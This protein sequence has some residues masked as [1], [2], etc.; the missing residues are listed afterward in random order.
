MSKADTELLKVDRDTIE[1][2]NLIERRRE[3]YRLHQL[4]VSLR[5]IAEQLGVA[6]ATVQRDIRWVETQGA[7]VLAGKAAELFS[8]VWARYGVLYKEAID[9]WV[10]SQEGTVTNT[11]KKVDRDDS[12]GRA[13]VTEQRKS[14]AGD[15]RF[16]TVAEACLAKQALLAGL[17]Q[18]AKGGKPVVRE[19]ER[20]EESDDDT[21][22]IVEVTT[23]EEA[24]A[25]EGKRYCRIAGPVESED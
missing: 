13:E 14:S 9:G 5:R 25:L 21:I 23:R 12:D 1:G 2:W 16:L 20:G 6:L 7:A 17:V 15:P 24:A 19:V 22:A 18:D 11:T 10:R 8:E 3:V 4:G